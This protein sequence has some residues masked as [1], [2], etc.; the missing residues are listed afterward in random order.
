MKKKDIKLHKRIYENNEKI[1][2]NFIFKPRVQ[3]LDFLHK[4]FYKIKGRILDI[5]AGNGYASIYTALKFKNVKETV[6]LEYLNDAKKNIKKNISFF[7]LENRSKR[8]Y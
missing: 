5:G 7:N 6:S 8:D 4:N 2:P 3:C 1:D